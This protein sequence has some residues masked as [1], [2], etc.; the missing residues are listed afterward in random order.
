M[1]TWHPAIV[2]FSI[3]LLPLSVVVD[4]LALAGRPYHGLA[5]GLFVGGVVGAL[6]AVL[7][8]D[9]AAAVHRQSSAAALI[10][11]HEDLA[12]AGL[13]L[14]LATGLARLP[15]Q[16]RG[17]TDGWQLKACIVV[18]G[19]VSALVWWSAYWGGKLVY[20]HGIGVGGGHGMP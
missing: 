2:H 3:V 17:Q 20:E 12:T 13:L 15:L 5:Y 11:R 14:A 9:A 8:G 19:A 16:L 10:E 4:L 18:A 1:E 7:S 6:A